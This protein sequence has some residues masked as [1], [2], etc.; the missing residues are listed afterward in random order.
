MNNLTTQTEMNAINSGDTGWLIISAGLVMLMIPG[1]AFFY[2]GMASKNNTLSTI[3]GF[4]LL[5]IIFIK[6]L[7]LAAS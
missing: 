3:M 7:V 6:T 2:G 4:N 5:D 1:L